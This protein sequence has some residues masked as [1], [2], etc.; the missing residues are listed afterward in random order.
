MSVLVSSH[1]GGRS[2][3]PK[4]GALPMRRC[5]VEDAMDV[6]AGARAAAAV[7]ARAL[8]IPGDPDDLAPGFDPLPTRPPLLAW[9]VELDAGGEPIAF[10]V[11]AYDLACTGDDGT[12]G[13]ALLT[14]DAAVMAEAG[15]LGT[16]GPRL[17][18]QATVGGWGVLVAAAPADLGRIGGHDSDELRPSGPFAGSV[19]ASS[20]ERERVADALVAALRAADERAAAFLAAVGDGSAEPTTGERGLALFV[21]DARSLRNLLDALRHAGELAG[22]RQ[23]GGESSPR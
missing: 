12:T 20:R 8:A 1:R 2:A 4:R 22:P 14:A 15:R 21:A 9:T 16:P 7:L 23:S 5:E 3:A 6:D 11:H 17:V 10:L 19:P 13:A 18:A